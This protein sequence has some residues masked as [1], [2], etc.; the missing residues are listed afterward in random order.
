MLVNEVGH[1][2]ENALGEVRRSFGGDYDP[3]YQCGYLIGGLQVHALYKEMVDGG[4]M[5][6]REFHDRIMAENFMPIA[7]LRA[8]I[9]GDEISRDFKRDWRFY[10]SQ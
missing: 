9:R 8:V 5:T 3:L 4:R 1:E 6:D 2:R 10:D 7:V